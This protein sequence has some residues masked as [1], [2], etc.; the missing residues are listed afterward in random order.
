MPSG[1]GPYVCS[2]LQVAKL[3]ESMPSVRHGPRDGRDTDEWA[4]FRRHLKWLAQTETDV[5]R[6]WS[7][8]AW[9]KVVEV[10]IFHKLK[11]LATEVAIIVSL[12]P[13]QTRYQLA[14]GANRHV[15]SSTRG[16]G[17]AELWEGS[18]G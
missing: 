13:R 9:R 15:L 8:W 17:E 7:C 18:I 5:E 2:D 3:N 6:S 1:W 4:R 12:V 16:G 14:P 10:E 11:R